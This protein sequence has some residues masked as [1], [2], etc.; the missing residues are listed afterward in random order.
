[1][2]R[3][4][5]ISAFTSIVTENDGNVDTEIDMV[6]ET[7]L[8]LGKPMQIHKDY[9]T[10]DEVEIM[11]IYVDGLDQD[12]KPSMNYLWARTVPPYMAEYGVKW[13]MSD[14]AV[15]AVTDE[16]YRMVGNGLTG[17]PTR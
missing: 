2:K 13:L 12:G 6:V 16:L 10:D 14:E 5:L 3:T 9:G 17:I 7:E 11:A 1:M 15:E 8:S 4:F